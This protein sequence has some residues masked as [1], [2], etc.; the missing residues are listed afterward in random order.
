MFDKIAIAADHAG[1]EMKR[2][3]KSFFGRRRIFYKGFRNI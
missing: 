3:I 1:F 2:K